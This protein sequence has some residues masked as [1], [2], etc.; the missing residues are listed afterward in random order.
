[1]ERELGSAWQDPVT[2]RTFSTLFDLILWSAGQLGLVASG[3]VEPACGDTDAPQF[4][5]NTMVFDQTVTNDNLV[6]MMATASEHNSGL[7]WLYNGP[8]YY[9]KH[10]WFDTRLQWPVPSL[11]YDY[12]IM[13][14]KESLI[15]KYPSQS[16]G[17]LM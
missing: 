2:G 15:P 9:P 7:T 1:L 14:T 17:R 6:V 3:F 10:F 13:K 16:I 11:Q 12:F 8:S 4:A 5:P